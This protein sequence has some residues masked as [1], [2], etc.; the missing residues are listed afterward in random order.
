M[1]TPFKAAA[2]QAAP[3]FL[4]LKAGVAKAIALIEEAAAQDVKLIAFPETWLPGYPWWI[5]L[6]APAVGMQYV[7]PYFQNSIEA[8]SDEDLALAEAARKNNIQVIMGVSERHEGSL[9]MGQ[10]H[11]DA[12]GDVISRRRKL[13]PTHVERAVFGEGDG[14]DIVVNETE[15]G[16]IG[17][18]CCWEHLQPLTKYAMF[19]Q[20]EQIHAAA[21]PSFSVYRGGAYQLGSDVNVC[22]ARQHAVEGQCF[23]L[24]ACATVSKEMIEMLCDTDVKR[25]FLL[26][27]GGYANIFGPDGQALAEPLA[28]TE[29]GLLI[30]E[31]N[32]DTIAI[33]KAAA[34]PTGHYSRPDVFRL[35]F[36]R[37]KNPRV[38]N[39]DEG[40]QAAGTDEVVERAEA[41]LEA[42][43]E[44]SE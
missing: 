24:S 39:F 11:Y 34:D 12:N 13:K 3:A 26:E 35:M 33:A 27:G 36:N 15:L 29:E 4:D 1:T 28:E 8:G 17:A 9:Y 23:V 16:R 5:W 21:W 37:S 2:V 31:I 10:W 42:V 7:V 19:S 20:N 44:Q 41:Q 25:Q 43:I 18:L 30:A 40:L 22:A 6:D 38:M 14:S 32:L